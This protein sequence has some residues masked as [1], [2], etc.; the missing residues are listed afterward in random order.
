MPGTCLCVRSSAGQIVDPLRASVPLDPA[1]VLH[2]PLRRPG[3][4]LGVGHHLV[5]GDRVSELEM[6]SLAGSSAESSPTHH[7][8]TFLSRQQNVVEVNICN[9][10]QSALEMLLINRNCPN[11]KSWIWFGVILRSK[12]AELTS[13]L[14]QQQQVTLQHRFP[15]AFRTKEL[16]T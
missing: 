14:R 2:D 7:S 16:E 13:I 1:E 9:R 8:V 12:V 10:P 15:V 11:T 4:V 6:Q 5:H 3:Q